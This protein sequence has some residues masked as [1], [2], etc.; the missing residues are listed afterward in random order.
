VLDNL[1]TGRRQNLTSRAEFIDGDISQ[2]ESI[3]PAFS[4]VDSVFHVAALPRVPLSIEQPLV[5]HMTNAVGTLNVLVAARDAG[6]RRLIY[7]ASSSAYGDQPTLPM[8]EDM[9]PNPL[10]P[11]AIEKL[12]GEYYTRVFHKLFGMQTLSLRYFNVFGP[13][14]ATEGAYLTV[15]DTFLRLRRAGQPLT[16][17]GDGEQTRD[18]THVS[19]VV[20]AN[21]L[22]MNCATA[23]GRVLN[24][25]QGRS[26]SVNHIARLIGGPTVNLAP[27]VGE[28]RHTLADFTQ[29]QAF[30]GWSP[31]VT[32]EQGVAELKTLAGIP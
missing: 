9:T 32:V 10:S 24:I 15:V 14:M 20:R 2:L 12:V 13:R 25:G 19:D 17:H 30:L 3:R 16:V 7:S 4:G 21:V 11:Y 1:S 29:A 8:R 6:V 5:T 18:F 27:R 22:A 23:D 28:P 26:V 31:R